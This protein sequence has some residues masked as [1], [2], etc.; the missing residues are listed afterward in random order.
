VINLTNPFVGFDR[1]VQPP[2]KG[3]RLQPV[4]ILTLFP[5]ARVGTLSWAA[6]QGSCRKEG[7]YYEGGAH[8]LYYIV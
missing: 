5:G 2:Q 7:A 3:H 4:C 1:I 8:C 6:L